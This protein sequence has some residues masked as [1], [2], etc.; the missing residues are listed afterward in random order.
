MSKKA[1]PTAIGAFVVGAIALAVAGIVVL[2]SGRF[3]QK[4][5]RSSASSRAA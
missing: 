3:F 4:T 2:G 5:S 1:S